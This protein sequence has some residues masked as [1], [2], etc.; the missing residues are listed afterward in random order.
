MNRFYISPQEFKKESIQITGDDFKHL[1]KVLRLEIDDQI[2]IFNGENEKALGIIKDISNSTAT[3]YLSNKHFT[4]SENKN[5]NLTLFQGIPKQGKMET[6][7]QKSTELGVNSI[8][9]FY[10]K[11]T[12]VKPSKNDR[13][14]INRYQRIAYEASKQC[15][16]GIIPT[17]N[18]PIKFSKLKEELKAYD[19]ILLAYENEENI[20]LKSFLKSNKELSTPVNLA[21]IIGPEGGFDESEINELKSQLPINIISL[22]NRILRTETAGIAAISQLNFFFES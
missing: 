21:L 19:L 20:T 11:R 14:K 17:I 15:G 5:F 16:R 3:I 8:Y 7:V 9:P 12:V 2:E 18:E 1:T 13:K 10:S 4:N 6:I 22:G